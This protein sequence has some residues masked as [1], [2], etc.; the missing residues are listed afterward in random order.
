M[1][2]T[3]EVT[4]KVQYI[5]S[6]TGELL[7]ERLYLRFPMVTLSICDTCKNDLSA[8]RVHFNELDYCMNCWHNRIG[9]IERYKSYTW[10]I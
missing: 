2:K 5:D 8:N 4:C 10:D 3:R 6:D 7:K 1:E 9:L